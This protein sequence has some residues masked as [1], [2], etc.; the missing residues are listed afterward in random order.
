MKRVILTLALIGLVLLCGCEDNSIIRNKSIVLIERINI[1]TA[2]SFDCEH[3]VI[4]YAANGAL[5]CVYV[6]K[7]NYI[8]ECE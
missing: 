6:P 4:C 3:R 5:S 2:Y 7:S 1:Q 8:E